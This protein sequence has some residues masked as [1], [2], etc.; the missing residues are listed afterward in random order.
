FLE[1][2]L[3]H[4]Y[5]EPVM[6]FEKT[7]TDPIE[8]GTQVVIDN[9]CLFLDA[10]VNWKRMIYKPSTEQEQIFAGASGNFKFLNTDKLKISLPLQLLAFHQG[11]Q[12]DTSPDPLQTL[13]NTALG[14]KMELSSRGFIKNLFTENYLAGY[15]EFSPTKQQL[16]SKGHGT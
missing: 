15:K 14:L 8:Y 1:G 2:N 3:Q 5:I 9:H 10:F 12:I 16:F 13:V 4:R 7:I 6:D 11:G